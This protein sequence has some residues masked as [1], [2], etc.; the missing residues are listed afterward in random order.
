MMTTRK[1][2]GQWGSEMDTELTH[3]RLKLV[4][5]DGSNQFVFLPL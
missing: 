4:A 5:Q 3:L 2:H 1:G